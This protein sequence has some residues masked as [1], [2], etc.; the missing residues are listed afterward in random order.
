MNKRM[1]LIGL[2]VMGRSLALNWAEQGVAVS[3]FSKESREVESFRGLGIENTQ[4]F[5][6]LDGFI[7]SLPKPRTILLMITAGSPVD[8]V[9]SRLLPFLEAD[10]IIIDG[11]NS[12]FKDTARRCTTL[13]EQGI[14][15][16]GCGISGGEA[17]ARYGASLMPGGSRSAWEDTRQMLEVLAARD[18]R[19]NR[20]YR[21]MGPDGAGHFVK[22]V[23][24]GI[25][26]ADMQLIGEAY[27]Y[28]WKGLG[29][30]A[31]EI[32]RV[33]SEWNRGDLH[34]YL[35]GI[36]AEIMGKRDMETGNPL[37]E[38]ILDR[39]GQKGTGKWT[40]QEALELGVPTPTLAEAVFSRCLSALKAERVEAAQVLV[41]PKPIEGVQRERAI[42][43]LELAL[44]A[45]K[46]SA[47]AQGVALLHAASRE[48]DWDLDLTAIASVWRAGCIIQADLVAKIEEAFTETPGLS[49][50][51]LAPYFQKVL[52]GA[53]QAWRSVI[54][55]AVNQGIPMGAF[56]SALAYYD[57][58]RS[59]QLPANLLQAQR[60][61]FGAHTYERIDRGGKYHTDWSNNDA[62][63]TSDPI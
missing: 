45:G 36:T 7:A 20:C 4:A 38:M 61:Y 34:S 44:Y 25:E 63:A 9:I 24:N 1:G 22:M 53:Q 12:Y 19:G 37:V 31:M 56:S 32:G 39:A 58:Y 13:R 21:Y 57:A 2:G 46:I 29:L 35:I 51:F 16:L 18:D 8:E 11:G 49:H 59:Q 43:E 54:A 15:F 28:M 41:G 47:Y 60:D 5:T 6:E 52:N 17:G 3:V 26:Y 55:D 10:D 40:A 23:H 62:N 50:L 30:S 48:Y 27:S 33:F 14:R 42:D